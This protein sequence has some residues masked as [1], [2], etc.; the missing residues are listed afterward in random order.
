MKPEIRQRGIERLLGGHKNRI[1][2]FVQALH[3]VVDHQ[4]ALPFVGYR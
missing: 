2:G 4:R 3:A 1:H